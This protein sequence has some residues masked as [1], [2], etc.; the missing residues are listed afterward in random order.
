M[1]TFCK[2]SS[3]LSLSLLIATSG[4]ETTSGSGS[5]PTQSGQSTT[6]STTSTGQT[7]KPWVYNRDDAY[8]VQHRLLPTMALDDAEFVDMLKATRNLDFCKRSKKGKDLYDWDAVT[9][10]VVAGDGNKIPDILFL[11]FLTPKDVSLC[12]Y[13]AIADMGATARYITLEKTNALNDTDK[14]ANLS[15]W[16]DGAKEKRNYGQVSYTDL[17]QFKSAV[18]KLLS[19]PAPTKKA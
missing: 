10:E 15:E 17:E 1:K 4:C 13:V 19:K 9:I 2:L 3:L 18:T 12:Y 6:K 8:F 5:S 11:T 7:T 16:Y 14:K